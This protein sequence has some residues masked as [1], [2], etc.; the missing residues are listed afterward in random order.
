[1]LW[2]PHWAIILES[3]DDAEDDENDEV[4]GLSIKSEQTL[5]QPKWFCVRESATTL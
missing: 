3:D 1:M 2:I 5:Q 4:S